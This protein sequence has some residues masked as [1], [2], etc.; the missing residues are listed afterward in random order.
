M[1][2][3]KIGRRVVVTGDENNLIVCVWSER[4]ML[5]VAGAAEPKVIWNADLRYLSG[6]KVVCSARGK[7]AREAVDNLSELAW[8]WHYVTLEAVEAIK[9]YGGN[10]EE[11]GETE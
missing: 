10:T 4:G 9:S 5:G 11:E 2:E 7:T 3:A 8:E 1:E 6:R